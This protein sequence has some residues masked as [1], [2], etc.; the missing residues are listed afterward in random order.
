MHTVKEQQQVEE[1]YTRV[2]DGGAL[3]ETDIATIEAVV[4]LIDKGTVRVA[5]KQGSD[6]KTN[7]W[8]KKAILLYFRA[9]KMSPMQAG[10]L[11]FYD[12]VPLKKWTG[13]EGVRSVPGSI[14]R[15]GSFISK[16]VVL[17]PSFVNIGAYVGEGTMV[18]TWATVG[19]CAQ[20]GAHVH[21]SGGVGI[22]GVLEPLQATPVIIEDHVFLG[23]RAIIVEGAVVEEGAV[24]G[25]G[26]T[27]TASTRIIDV[28]GEEAVTYR[29]RVPANSVVI[30]GYAPKEFAAGL[31]GV[32]CALIIGKRS[33]TTDKKTSL[34]NVLR[35]FN[36]PV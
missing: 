25:A 13:D 33:A 30:P 17:M 21:I 20:V 29:G 27:I 7:E 9:R 15:F 31:Y 19:S 35:D 6:W 5:E 12:K 11:S 14:A 18:D 22:G 26:V 24:I 16:N 4:E 23:S 36:V 28:T 32:P 8:A 10:D 1:I 34:N 2:T 3:S